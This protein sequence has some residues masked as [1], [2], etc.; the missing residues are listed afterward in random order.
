[1]DSYRVH[2]YQQAGC[3][4]IDSPVMLGVW[5]LTNGKM[6][7]TGCHA[8]NKGNCKF[9]KKLTATTTASNQIQHSETVRQEA[10]RRGLS[11]SEIRRQRNAKQNTVSS[12]ERGEGE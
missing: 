1:M 12:E 7:D 4:E 5:A 8:F 3:P 10:A 9:Y 2:E 11:I 6:C